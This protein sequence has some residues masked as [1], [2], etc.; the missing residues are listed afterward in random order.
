VLK[1]KDSKGLIIE[2]IRKIF[3][4][5]LI[6]GISALAHAQTADEVYNTYIDFNEARLNADADRALTLA[7]KILPDTAKLT[8]KV[9]TSFYNLL[10]KLY[11]EDNQSIKA[12]K[13]YNL[14]IAAQP[15]YYIAHRALGYL[16]I[17]DIQNK[18]AVVDLAY[19][20]KAKNAL[21]HLEKAQA[22]EPDDNTL[23]IIKALYKNLRDEKSIDTLPARMESLKK[24]CIDLLSD[25]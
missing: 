8:Q 23:M 9:R 18:Q 16:Y 3:L 1:P 14:V 4:L 15:N 19:I 7:D 22:C 2:M 10:A 21:P 17:K 11:E 12:I 25:Q 24:N 5:V 20:T 6:A 13:Y